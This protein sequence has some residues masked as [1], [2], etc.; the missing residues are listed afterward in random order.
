V[1]VLVASFVL[2]V[3]LT[4][5]FQ[6]LGL[7]VRGTEKVEEEVVATSIASDLVD[8]F[9][10]LPNR[11]LPVGPDRNSTGE[12]PLSAVCAQFEKAGP[13][14]SQAVRRKLDA[15]RPPDG[16]GV[17]VSFGRVDPGDCSGGDP[18]RL[19]LISVTVAYTTPAS[20]SAKVSCRIT[21]SRIVTDDGEVGS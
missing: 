7:S 3:A 4:A 8:F 1:E 18:V 5:V 2:V 9:A 13:Q 21:L 15:L 20:P 12:L 14:T 16:Y 10:S 19:V 6:A 11:E 17:R